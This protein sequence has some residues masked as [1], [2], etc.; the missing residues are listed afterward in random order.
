M[1]LQQPMAVCGFLKIKVVASIYHYSFP[2][3]MTKDTLKLSVCV[4]IYM[5]YF[6]PCI[7]VM[8]KRVHF[9]PLNL[10][11][12]SFFFSSFHLFFSERRNWN[13]FAYSKWNY[14]K[15]NKVKWNSNIQFLLHYKILNYVFMLH[16]QIYKL[17]QEKGCI[18]LWIFSFIK[19]I[20]DKSIILCGSMLKNWCKNQSAF[21]K[22]IYYIREMH[23]LFYCLQDGHQTPQKMIYF[24]VPLN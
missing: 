18:F 10:I 5:N 21:C 2:C 4:L 15:P 16:C 14:S 3:V 13:R 17:L 1:L 9:F 12:F 11:I 19:S 22:L 23:C 24:E 8:R 7:Y 6:Y 20:R